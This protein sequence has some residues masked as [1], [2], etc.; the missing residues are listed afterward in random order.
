MGWMVKCECSPVVEWKCSP[1]VEWKCRCCFGCV[2]AL[3][4]QSAV[5]DELVLHGEGHRDAQLGLVFHGALDRLVG[6]G[7]ARPAAPCHL[8]IRDRARVSLESSEM[9]AANQRQSQSEPRKLRDAGSQ[10][11]TEPE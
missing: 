10:S 7:V 1:V 3:S 9:Q 5:Q 2:G 8:P 6:V 11:Q 4:L